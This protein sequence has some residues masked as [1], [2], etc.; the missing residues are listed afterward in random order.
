MQAQATQRS[1]VPSAQKVA[2]PAMMVLGPSVNIAQPPA[3]A[4]TRI[5]A[6]IGPASEH[7]DTVAKLIQAGV[8]IFRFNFSHG[9]F[10][11]HKRRL[12]TVRGVAKLLRTPTACMGDLQGPKIRVGKVPSPGIELVAG[13]DVIIRP[14]AEVATTE[15]WSG[16]QVVVLPT[17]YKQLVDEV[18]PGHRV[19]INDGLIRMLAVARAPDR[20]ELL[21]RV[22]VGGLVT[23]GKGINLPQ[24][25]ISAKAITD[26]DWECVHWAVEHGLDLLALSFVRTADEVLELK[27]ALSGMC[28]IDRTKA[29]HVADAGGASRIPVVA[30]IEKPQAVNNIEEIVEAADVIMVARGDLGVEMDISQ[31]PV[32]QKSIIASCQHLAKPC[33]VATQM[34]ETMVESATP[35]R[36]EA[37]DVGNAIFDGADAIMLSAETATGKHPVLVVET[38]RRIAD[39]AESFIAK[40]PERHGPPTRWRGSFDGVA[41]LAHG[42]K[43]VAKDIGASLIACWSESGGAARV[44]SMFDFNIPIIAYSSDVR[45]SRRM[46]VNR[47]VIPIVATP[48]A[49]GIVADWIEQA[50]RDLIQRGL[51]KPGDRAVMIAGKPVGQVGAVQAIVIH[52]FTPA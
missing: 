4:L 49:S 51:A 40:G 31:V 8:S 29:D 5:V 46:I 36:A 21:C 13:R 14:G 15:S 11:D 12:D 30:K 27:H 25:Q 16:E 9:S 6:T 41:A 45:A 20:G 24:S 43:Y 7:P 52:M 50:N 33:I 2:D 47:G 39:T 28:S 37:S 42:A 38:M 35:T 32:A 44:L 10:E 26:K 3:R 22:T 1:D 23:S 48:P 18:E 19:L 34:L 17:T